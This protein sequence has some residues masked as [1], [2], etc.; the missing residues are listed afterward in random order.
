[1]L[2]GDPT[3]VSPSKIGDITVDVTIVGGKVVYQK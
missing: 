2:S 1:V 3:A